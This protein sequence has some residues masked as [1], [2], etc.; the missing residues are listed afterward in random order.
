M[1]VKNTHSVTFHVIFSRKVIQ[2]AFLRLHFVSHV[3]IGY[4]AVCAA[5]IYELEVSQSSARCHY[6]DLND[7]TI[8]TEIFVFGS[9]ALGAER[10]RSPS[11][12]VKVL[13]S[14]Q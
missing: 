9:Q 5:G 2:N 4:L 3:S 12:A 8:K 1:D 6:V 13:I 10:R 7:K 11:M 14:I